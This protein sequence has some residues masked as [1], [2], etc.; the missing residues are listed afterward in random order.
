MNTKDSSLKFVPLLY[1]IAGPSTFLFLIFF[2][3]HETRDSRRVTVKRH[4]LTGRHNSGLEWDL[5]RL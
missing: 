1:F 3:N 5:S 2:V 4:L